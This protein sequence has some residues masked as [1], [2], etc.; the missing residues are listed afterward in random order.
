MSTDWQTARGAQMRPDERA[1]ILRKS[2]EMA[3]R[4]P[5]PV[6]VHLGVEYGASVVCSQAGAPDARIVGVDLEVDRYVGPPVELVKGDSAEQAAKFTGPVHFLFVD[7]DHTQ[8]GVAAD[9]RAWL[10]KVRPGG[11]VAFHDYEQPDFPHVAGVREAVNAWD[12]AKTTWKHAE[13]PGSV[14]AFERLPYL[15][16]GDGFGTV[17]IGTPYMKAE[18]DFFRWW[19]WLLIGGLED[20]DQLLNDWSFDCPMPIPVAHNAIIRRFL[21]TDRDTLLLIEDDHCGDQPVVRQMRQK[22]ENYDY[23]IVCA[24]YVNRRGFPVPVGFRF[25]DPEPTGE[26]TVAI[27]MN[28]TQE[29][30]TEEV[31]G[32]AMG[33]MLARRWVLEAMLGDDPPE[34]H[35]WAEWRGRN[36]QDL[37]F[38]KWAKAV[39]ARAGVDRDA[40]IGHIAKRIATFEDFLTARDKIATKTEG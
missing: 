14:V 35:Q 31:D 26:L 40:R 18:Y 5:S 22:A 16:R 10:G 1:W 21:E 23:D 24:T 12:W 17:G 9:M 37:W 34:V 25:I 33:C 3:G 28:K 6:L 30:G 4:F 7:A 11:I 8:N 38:Y 32:S 13:A 36:S 15:R 19:S 29:H 20:G 2:A 27:D 39:G